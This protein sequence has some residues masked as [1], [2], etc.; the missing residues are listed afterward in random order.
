M[1]QN[2][3]ASDPAAVDAFTFAATNVSGTES[4][5]S[6]S[7]VGPAGNLPALVPFDVRFLWD[8][9]S[10]T[11][12]KYYSVTEWYAD[13]AR[14]QGLGTAPLQFF[15]GVNDTAFETDTTV[16]EVGDVVTLKAIVQPN[17]TLEDRSYDISVPI[18]A[19]LD[20]DPTSISDGGTFDGNSV[21][22][23]VT[24][25]SLLGA[26]GSYE[27]STPASNAL[28]DTGFG[29]YVNLAGFGILPSPT[30]VGDTIAGTFFSA[31]NPV[32]FFGSPRDSGFTV[33]DD[34]FGFFDSAPGPIPYINIPIPDPF[35]PNDMLA[36]LWYDWVTNYDDGSVSG[37]ER[38]ITAATAGADV[39]IIEWDGVEIWPGDGGEPIVADFQVVIFSTPDP[40]FP[41]FVFAYD[42]IDEAYLA[43]AP[44]GP[45]TTGVEN[46]TGTVGSQ[47]TD[48][49]TN[50]LVVCLDYVGP[51]T[52]P[53]ELSFTAVPQA[54]LGGQTVTVTESDTVDNPGSRQVSNSVEIQVNELACDTTLSTRV[55]RTKVQLNW[56]HTGDDSYN[57]YR[58]DDSG[59]PYDLI[60]DTT[61]TYSTF[62][63]TSG[64][65]GEDYFYLVKGVSDGLERC[66]SN[67]ASAT[68][69]SGRRR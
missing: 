26:E 47:Y 48:P 18:P 45:T 37:K 20:V 3:A 39:S 4:A 7:A 69:S 40:D 44:F 52:A 19:G 31:Q 5:G 29:G 35:E 58:G 41:E 54:S 66:T 2:W 14:T 10:E 28:C 27:F 55:K 17:L 62:I 51:D 1:I 53:R 12:D 8:I 68:L 49:I 6:L 57:V 21:E 50:G 65:S 61:S 33:T 64:V 43:N 46:L 38:G 23:M 25:Q 11:G 13:A 34:G 56:M 30:F 36:P 63:D 15:R 9:P 42:N 22:W 32:D 16:A 60:G 67:E 24:Q 59:G